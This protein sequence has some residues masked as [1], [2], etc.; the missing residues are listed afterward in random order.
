MARIGVFSD[1]AVQPAPM[2]REEWKN[3]RNSGP[4]IIRWP[5]D[6]TIISPQVREKSRILSRG[7]VRSS[8]RG[9]QGVF[10]PGNP[11]QA[12]KNQP[13]RFTQSTP[14][15]I[16]QVFLRYGV[17]CQGD[18]SPVSRIFSLSDEGFHLV[19]AMKIIVEN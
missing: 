9:V 10:S 17:S 1:K 3:R 13:T 5:G 12:L 15:P 6:T 19:W 4:E 8:F 14:W 11:V 7:K 2:T 16:K 18:K